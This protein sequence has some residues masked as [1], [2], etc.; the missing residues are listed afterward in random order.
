MVANLLRG[1]EAPEALDRATASLFGV[2]KASAGADELRLVDSQ[3]LLGQ[4]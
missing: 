1:C 3:D 4:P 2:I